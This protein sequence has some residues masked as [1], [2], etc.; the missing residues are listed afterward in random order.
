MVTKRLTK[1]CPREHCK[2]HL[3]LGKGPKQSR[4]AKG[5]VFSTPPLTWHGGLCHPARHPP[6]APG[7]S[8]LQGCFSGICCIEQKRVEFYTEH[9]VPWTWLIA[10]LSLQLPPGL[11]R[12][13]ARG[14]D[15]GNARRSPGAVMARQT[16][17]LDLLSPYNLCSLSPI[18][19]P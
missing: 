10:G 18:D 9:W 19:D 11:L 7:T 4:R 5:L 14:R 6:S 3:S 17:T 15:L 8:G 16:L 13:L 1:H 12:A 2:M